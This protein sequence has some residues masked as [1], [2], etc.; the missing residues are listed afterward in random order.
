VSEPTT[1]S[2]FFANGQPY[3]LLENFNLPVGSH[4]HVFGYSD[5]AH[6]GCGDDGIEVIALSLDSVPALSTTDSDGDLLP[7][8]WE[9][10]M[11]GNLGQNGS[12]D[13]DGDGVSNLQEFLDHTDSKDALSKSALAQNVTPPQIDV[14]AMGGNQLKLTWKWPNQYAGKVKFE[15]QST[16]SLD[17]PFAP[18][19]GMPQYIGGG[20]F[21]LLLPNPGSG[22]RLYRLQL[23]LY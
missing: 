21:E 19:L 15:V 14:Q 3:R 18:T 1:K 7:D 4:V 22:M 11:F 12:G 20:Q 13:S 17:Q 9:M 23:S 16:E 5:I 2:L 8:N 10:L 6:P